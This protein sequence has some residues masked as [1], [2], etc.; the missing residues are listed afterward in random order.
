MAEEIKYPLYKGLQKPLM[1]KGLKGKYIYIAAITAVSSLIV[2]LICFGL[3]GNFI[4]ILVLAIGVGG[5]L[6]LIAQKQKKGLYSK[7]KLK[8]VFVIKKGIK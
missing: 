2:S 8:G 1:F 4:G 5:G 3:F 6:F 7:K